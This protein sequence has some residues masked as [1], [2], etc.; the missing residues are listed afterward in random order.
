MKRLLGYLVIFG[1][2]VGVGF[3]WLNYN[4]WIPKNFPIV[5]Q[6]D[7]VEAIP[8]IAWEDVTSGRLANFL[9]LQESWGKLVVFPNQV[10][11]IETYRMINPLFYE[12]HG[13]GYIE[14]FELEIQNN[15]YINPDIRPY[16]YIA[17]YKTV[18]S[19][20]LHYILIFEWLN[21]DK[22]VSFVPVVIP[23]NKFVEGGKVS[24]YAN[25]LIK[26]ETII[27][28]SPIV[29]IRDMAGCMSVFTSSQEYCEWYMSKASEYY[30]LVDKWYAGQKVPSEVGR[31]PM[32]V[33]KTH[34]SL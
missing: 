25:E 33:T 8:E 32:L 4:G 17:A 22:T 9:R 24:Q 20:K 31:Y 19:N 28:V 2:I 15:K 12:N 27:F 13:Y 5:S 7:N 26:R 16:R 11:P 18:I 29:K 3:W 21:S 23:E 30:E 1:V 10:R 34:V 6:V 14:L